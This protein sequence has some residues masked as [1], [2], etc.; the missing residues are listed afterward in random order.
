MILNKNLPGITRPKQK[1]HGVLDF[2]VGPGKFWKIILRIFSENFL[3]KNQGRNQR[4]GRR[5][6]TE[7]PIPH[8]SAQLWTQ[9]KKI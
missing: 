7:V 8:L 2:K 1:H 3:R 9:N 5:W 6:S 4:G